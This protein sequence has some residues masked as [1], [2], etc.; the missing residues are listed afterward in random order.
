MA[1]H[2]TPVREQPEEAW[3]P[4]VAIVDADR[5]IRH[6]LGNL[7]ALAGLTVVGQAGTAA[8]ALDLVEAQRPSVVLIDASLPDPEAGEALI[9]AI[10][11]RHPRL[12]VVLM[13]WSDGP[14][15]GAHLARIGGYLRKDLSPEE[16]VAAATIAAR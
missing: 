14:H 9:N 7:L 5:R 12:R 13:G 16:F 2:T 6:S 8:E 4:R 3:P 10:G 15:P 1:T 11:A